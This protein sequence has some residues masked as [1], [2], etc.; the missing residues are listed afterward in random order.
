MSARFQ[1]RPVLFDE[2]IEAMDIKP[3][4]LYIDGTFGRGGHSA[5]IL[6]R[7]GQDG[8]LMVMD[9]DPQAINHARELYANEPRV[10]IVHDDYANLKEH[11]EA[12]GWAESVDGLL[13]DLGVSS[14][15]LDD[16][17]RG[18]SFAKNGPLD[19]RMNP[20]QGQSAAQW[21]MA[22]PEL[23][24][25]NVLWEFGE[26]R[27]SR[28][29]ARKIVAYREDQPIADT[30]TLSALIA[31]VVPASKKNKH[32]ATRSFQAIRIWINRELEHVEKVLSDL[33]DILSLGGRVLVI[34]FHSL[35]DRLIKRFFKK[36]STQ[37]PVPKGLPLRDSELPVTI[38]L[39][40]IGK[41]L[42]AGA[43]ELAENPRS[44]SATLRIAQRVA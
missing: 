35:E 2:V 31:E 8:R 27:M 4:G 18:F 10:T 28:R 12:K 26:E 25:A 9:K 43:E 13:L 30:A 36:Y 38:K 7:L 39:K 33:F 16:A 6:E 34:S 17:E 32:P 24:I 44:R 19:M 3:E 37:E 42:K 23:E 14:P 29:I 21:L 15:Q 40:L 20:Q 41:A 5:A 1:H 22:A 11:V